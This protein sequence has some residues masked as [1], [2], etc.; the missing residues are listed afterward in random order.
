M[1][2]KFG[3]S[4]LNALPTRPDTQSITGAWVG[5]NWSAWSRVSQICCGW[6][7]REAH[8][9]DRLGGND[10]MRAMIAGNGL[11]S[12]AM[13]RNGVNDIFVEEFDD[14]VKECLNS[15]KELWYRATH[16]PVPTKQSANSKKKNHPK[17]EIPSQSTNTAK[18]GSDLRKKKVTPKPKKSKKSMK[19]DTDEK[20]AAAPGNKEN[21]QPKKENVTWLNANF[22]CLLNLPEMMKQFGPLSN[23]YDAGGKG[24]KMIHEVKPDIPT[25]LRPERVKFFQT[26]MEK[27]FGKRFMKHLEKKQNLTFWMERKILMKMKSRIAATF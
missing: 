8:L 16:T 22:L 14:Y 23:L 27:W 15:T 3:L 11:I 25:S 21:T 4:W 12:R 5:E 10:V 2:K 13:S 7:C 17:K 18:P 26:V 20:P 19:K 9:S 24:E 6:L 1:L